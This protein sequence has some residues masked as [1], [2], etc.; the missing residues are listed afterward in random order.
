MIK[1][2]FLISRLARPPSI[3]L[4]E[5]FPCL[6]FDELELI[7]DYD[8]VIIPNNACPL[9]QIVDALEHIKKHKEQIMGLANEGKIIFGVGDGFVLLALAGLFG[10]D[11]RFAPS[12]K[13]NFWS[14]LSFQKS[15][16]SFLFQNANHTLMPIH[17]PL[18]KVILSEEDERYF[19]EMGQV[20]LTYSPACIEGMEDFLHIPCKI[21]G[22]CN[23]HGT[24][25]GMMPDPFSYLFVYQ[26]PLWFKM[27]KEIRQMDGAGKM[28]LN[29]IVN[30]LERF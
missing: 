2:C 23:A 18:A 21:A 19:E 26:N 29:C 17:H 11:V 13:T 25:L 27:K 9:S 3:P 15:A 28:F 5:Q 7:E 4:S 24:I 1:S 16:C 8:F 30:H 22:L 20:F 10:R 14:L 12:S 6:Y